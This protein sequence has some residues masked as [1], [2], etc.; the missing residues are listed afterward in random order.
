MTVIEFAKMMGASLFGIAAFSYYVA[1]IAEKGASESSKRRLANKFKSMRLTPGARSAFSHF[2]FSAD[3]YFGNAIFSWKALRR[4]VVLSLSWVLLILALC[5]YMYPNYRSWLGDRL[6]GRLILK[7]SL[8]LLF[9]SLV[10]DFLSVCVTRVLVRWSLTRSK[11]AILGIAI[12]DIAISAVIF[13]VLFNSAKL[14]VAPGGFSSP[15]ESLSVWANLKGLPILLQTL[16]DLTSD[17]LRR[18]P[19]GTVEIVGGL[20]TEI[21]YAFPEGIVFFSSLLTSVWMWLYV[22][23]YWV[24]VAAVRIDLV[25][26][27][28]EP[29]L[30]TEREPFFAIAYAIF[31]VALLVSG[32]ATALFSILRWWSA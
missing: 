23:A 16:N 20:N 27:F 19:D 22:T 4:S 26:T 21:V 14:V 2:L 15:T 1:H 31:V 29:H 30:N 6:M 10:I 28:L 24:V 9:A 18:L 8:W 3:R 17:M 11:F 25:K 13:Y 12:A 32:V 5:L 7:S